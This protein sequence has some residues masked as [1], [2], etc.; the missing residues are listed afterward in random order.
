MQAVS[1]LESK[2]AAAKAGGDLRS[3]A[4]EI[5]CL[6]ALRYGQQVCS[7]R[8]RGLIWG[9]GLGGRGRSF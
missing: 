2:A 4:F 1:A 6:A 3:A 7:G 5:I 9:A 8:V